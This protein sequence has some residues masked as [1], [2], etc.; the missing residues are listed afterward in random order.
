MCSLRKGAS[1]V[2][3]LV[4]RWG[5]MPVIICS[6]SLEFLKVLLRKTCGVQ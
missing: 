6:M 2:F 3:G 4:I 5:I 1:K